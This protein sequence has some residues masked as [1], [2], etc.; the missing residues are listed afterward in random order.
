MFCSADGRLVVIG[1]PMALTPLLCSSGSHIVVF[2]LVNSALLTASGTIAA[3]T[4]VASAT[5][6]ILCVPVALLTAFGFFLLNRCAST[7]LTW[8]AFATV[9]DCGIS[10]V[11]IAQSRWFSVNVTAIPFSDIHSLHLSRSHDDELNTYQYPLLIL[12]SKR[13]IRVA[14]TIEQRDLRLIGI[15]SRI[16]VT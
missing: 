3:H 10:E 2:F 12:H 14:P 15:L 1:Q 4:T 11:R 8:G 7:W 9:F 16:R 13:A 5:D 6:L